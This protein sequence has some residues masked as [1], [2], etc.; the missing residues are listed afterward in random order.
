MRAPHRER[1]TRNERRCAGFGAQFDTHRRGARSVRKFVGSQI[2]RTTDGDLKIAVNS[3]GKS[4]SGARSGEGKREEESS[5]VSCSVLFL[6]LLDVCKQ[7]MSC[8]ICH[9]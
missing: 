3:R 2:V 9:A 6:S 7:P 1:E 4:Q 8:G 5:I